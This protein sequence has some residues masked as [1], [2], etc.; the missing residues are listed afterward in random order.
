MIIN[1]MGVTA[2]VV[3]NDVAPAIRRGSLRFSSTSDRLNKL[4]KS[5]AESAL[6]FRETVID[7]V[8]NGVN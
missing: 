7:K 4:N 1:K 6:F 5:V 2:N 3:K 8:V